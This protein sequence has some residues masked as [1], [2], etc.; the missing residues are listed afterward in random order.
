L[1]ADEEL[2]LDDKEESKVEEEPEIDYQDF[3]DDM[4]EEI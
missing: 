4:I 3:E 2:K 1:S